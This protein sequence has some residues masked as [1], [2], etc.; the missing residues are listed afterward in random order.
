MTSDTITFPERISRAPSYPPSDD[1]CP[2]E[3]FT[4]LS[5]VRKRLSLNSQERQTPE[6]TDVT[7]SWDKSPKRSSLEPVIVVPTPDL[8]TQLRAVRLDKIPEA[9]VRLQNLAMQRCVVTE[10]CASCQSSACPVY[11]AHSPGTPSPAQRPS[12][13]PNPAPIMA[14]CH[15]QTTV[16]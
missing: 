8:A 4:H 11:H 10:I 14:N 5:T 2:Q 6:L 7:L 12:C 9:V 3:S 13:L 16:P 1:N 15:P